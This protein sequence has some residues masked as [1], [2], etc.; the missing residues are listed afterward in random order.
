MG[1]SSGSELG[2]SI[3]SR[4]TPVTR[5]LLLALASTVLA[6]LL[7]ELILPLFGGTVYTPPFYLGEVE[8]ERDATYDPLLGW[9][10]PPEAVLTETREEYSVSYTS[11][12]QGFRS[13]RDFTDPVKGRRIALLGDSYTFGSGVEDDETFAARLESLLEDTWCDNLG[14]GAFGIDQMWLALRHYALPL[15]P[16]LVILSFVRPD[17]DRSLSSYRKDHIWRW[18]PAFRLVGDRPVPMTMDNRPG[19]IRRF[20]HRESRLYRYWRK[21][22]NSFSRRSAFGYRWRLNRAL[23]EAIR[24]ECLEAAVPLVVVHIPISRRQ[25]APMFRREFAKIGIQYLDLGSLLPADGDALYYPH[26]SHFN[27]AGHRFAAEAI[28]QFLVARRLAAN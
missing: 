27:A 7:C 2:F 10:L 1:E 18:K 26:D 25:P 22:E 23:F 20:V 28:H 24:D 14:I 17:L 16:D 5:K 11:N 15:K 3:N 4:T 12:A 13:Q 21:L 19:P 8:A 9:K 6:A